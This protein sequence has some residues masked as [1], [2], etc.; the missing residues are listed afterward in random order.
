MKRI[1]VVFMIMFPVFA[2]ADDAKKGTIIN[3][4]SCEVSATNQHE[5]TVYHREI[6]EVVDNIDAGIKIVNSS[7]ISKELAVFLFSFYVELKSAGF[8]EQQ[9]LSLLSITGNTIYDHAK[10]GEK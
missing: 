3:L 4:S 2:F 8:T 6:K 1:I 10:R 9:A 7:S 5:S